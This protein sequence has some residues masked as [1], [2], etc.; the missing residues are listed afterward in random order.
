VGYFVSGMVARNSE[1]VL[2]L[3]SNLISTSSGIGNLGVHVRVDSAT[4]TVTG[5]NAGRNTAATFTSIPA[6]ASD[7]YVYYA[8]SLPFTQGSPFF[9]YILIVGIENDTTIS[10]PGGTT[11]INKLQTLLISDPNDLTGTKIV[12]NKQVSVFSGHQCGN[13]PVGV[14]FCDL[15]V[16]QIPPTTVWGTVYYTAPLA[17]RM[18]YT[19]KVVAANDSTNVDIYCNDVKESYSLNEAGSATKTASNTEYC[20]IISDKPILVAQLAHG[21]QDDNI[22]GDPMMT[23]VPATN[24]Y[25]NNFQFS[26]LQG[27]PRYTHYI[28]NIALEEDFQDDKINIVEC[29]VND[30]LNTPW[31]PIKVNGVTVARA[32]QFETVEGVGEIFH[33][34]AN[35]KMSVVVYGFA[36]FE[37]YGHPAR[38]RG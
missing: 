10:Y 2:N 16:Q 22:N 11:M 38:I 20:A 14:G 37:S 32:R 4:V 36:P 23:L 28:N 21:Q 30:S 33:G 8:V 34:G 15:I 18:S 24:Q 13:F 17:T 9:S 25:D 26:T 35:A 1:V 3:P 6:M 12:A 19:I 7:S 5:Q 27:R 29:G 31:V